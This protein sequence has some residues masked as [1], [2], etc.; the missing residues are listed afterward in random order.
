MADE[1]SVAIV[2]RMTDEASPEMENLGRTM[3][4]TSLKTLDMR[5]SMLAMGGAMSAVGGLLRQI[6]NPTAKAASNF[7]MIASAV[8]MSAAAIQ[9]LIP[10]IQQATAAMRSMAIV[11]GVLAAL[12]GPA[13]WAMLG[14][15][16]AVG[17]GATYGIMRA[18]GGSGAGPTQNIYV[19]G[20]IISERELSDITRRNIVDTQHRNAN[21][22]GIQ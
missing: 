8:M 1:A 20:S 13:G 4:Q 7:L 3:E 12:S 11:K 9:Q 21:K 16:A 10:I 15:G 18:T 6:D 14:A 17:V 19:Q 22:S 2:A 5:M